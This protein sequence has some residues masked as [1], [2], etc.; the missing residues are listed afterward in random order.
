MERSIQLPVGSYRLTVCQTQLDEGE[1]LI[2]IYFEYLPKPQRL[3][4]ILVQDDGLVPPPRLI[5]TA[6]VAGED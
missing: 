4:K 1:E 6:N 5:E 2:D 3:S